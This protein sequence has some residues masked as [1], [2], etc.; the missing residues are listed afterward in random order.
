MTN[1]TP[2]PEENQRINDQTEEVIEIVEVENEVE[3]EQELVLR[4]EGLLHI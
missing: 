1:S 4:I 2:D 3:E